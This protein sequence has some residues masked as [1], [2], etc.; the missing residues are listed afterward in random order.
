MLTL[1]AQN[2]IE[3]IDGLMILI[4]GQGLTPEQE[5]LLQDETIEHLTEVRNMLVSVDVVGVIIIGE[6]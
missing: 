2:L 5:K 4:N 3:E 6:D 1:L